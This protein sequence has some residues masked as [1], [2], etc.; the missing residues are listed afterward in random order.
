MSVGRRAL[1]AI[2]EV[3]PLAAL[4]EL[5]RQELTRVGYAAIDDG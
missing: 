4:E 5:V 2:V 1:A 3:G